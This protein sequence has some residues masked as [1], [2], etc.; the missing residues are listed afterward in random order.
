MDCH[1]TYR[2]SLCTKCLYNFKWYIEYNQYQGWFPFRLAL[3]LKKKT[4]HLD[5]VI[6][7]T[8]HWSWSRLANVVN[9][10]NALPCLE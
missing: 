2:F 4:F 7:R 1:S 6:S 10:T 3:I 5:R 9:R 8:S